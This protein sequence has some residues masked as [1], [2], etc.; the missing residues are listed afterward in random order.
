MT[1]LPII[2]AIDL[3]SDK[4]VTLIATGNS[5]T[6]QLEVVGISVVESK[7]VKKSMIVDLEE[8]ISVM[9]ESVNSAERMAG[10]KVK[11]AYVS[12]SGH[13]IASQNSKGVVAV[14]APNQEIGVEDVQKVIESARAV[15]V[16]TD[17]TIIHVI[18]KDFRIDSQSGIKDPT[19][20]IGIRLE[21]SAHIITSL[22]STLKNTERCLS[23]MGI[24]VSGFVFSGL[25]S[26]ESIATE[27]EKELGVAVVDIGA[28]TT[29]MC[30]YVDGALEFSTTIPV[31]ARHITQDL[32]LGCGISIDSAEKIK[33]ALSST[34]QT[35]I[36]PKPGESKDELTKRRKVADQLTPQEY[37]VNE[38][39][40]VQSRKLLIEKIMVPRMNEI[41]ILLGQQLQRAD[42]FPMIPAGVIITGG[43][44]ES[45]GIENV[46]K[47]T[48][49]LPARVGLP[50]QLAGLTA[51]ILRPSF[52]TSIGLLIYGWNQKESQVQAQ[53]LVLP[54]FLTNFS[55]ASINKIFK[56]FQ[57]I[58][59]SLLP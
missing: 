59:K 58:F 14:A 18:P 31:G 40:G 6:N 22:L 8:A 57:K 41:F 5:S 49:R 50:P 42:L 7:G 48:L 28:G 29:T 34:D 11:S 12:L 4:C 37:G 24:E 51:D 45:I 13:H 43:G 20:M 2:T 21:S 23:D 17:R 44:A 33:I 55:F 47:K 25:A 26:S 27:T 1:K 38:L 16:P 15:S 36:F 19:G 39:I 30:V 3:G 53:P 32:A 52:A 10:V 56:F 9:T 35:E 46:A 54:S